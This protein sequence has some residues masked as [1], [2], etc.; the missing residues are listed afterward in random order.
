MPRG[1]AD[2]EQSLRLEVSAL[3]ANEARLKQELDVVHTWIDERLDPSGA[4]PAGENCT[5]TRT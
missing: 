2:R 1:E 4:L 5:R 3:L